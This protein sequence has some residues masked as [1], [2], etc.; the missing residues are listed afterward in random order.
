MRSLSFLFQKAVSLITHPCH[1][2]YQGLRRSWDFILQVSQVCRSFMDAG[3]RYKIPGSETEGLYSQASKQHE[4][5]FASIP[6]PQ[7]HSRDMDGPRWIWWYTNQFYYRRVT[8]S[9]G[10]PNILC[11][12]VTMAIWYLRKSYYHCL[13]ICSRNILENKVWEKG[14]QHLYSQQ[15]YESSKKNHFLIGVK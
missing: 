14:S 13:L 8:L 12:T 2:C 9:L 1:Q 5:I 3:S 7:S 15:K 10:N 4:C 6:V 11:C